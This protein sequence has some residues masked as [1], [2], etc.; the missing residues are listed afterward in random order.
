LPFAPKL[1]SPTLLVVG[2]VVRFADPLALAQQFE[3]PGM[4]AGSLPTAVSADF[5][6]HQEQLA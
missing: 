4:A 2:K 3:V 5:E 6:T 1:A